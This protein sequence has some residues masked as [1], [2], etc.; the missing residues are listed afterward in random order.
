MEKIMVIMKKDLRETLH[1]KAFYVSIGIALF[2]LVMLSMGL[3]RMSGTLIEEGSSPS[4]ITLTIQSLIGTTTFMLSLMLMMLFCIYINAYT[5]T[6]EKIKRSIESL[7]CTPLS[8]KQIYLG[9]SLAVFLPS[10]ILGLVFTFGS[11]VGINYFFIVPKLGHFVI[12]GAAPL[13]ATL[14]VVPLITFFLASLMTALQLILTNIRWINAAFMGVIFA[15]GFGLSPI[16]K[17]GPS[18]WNLVLLSVGIAAVLA[19]ITFLLSSRVT[20]ERIVLS[21]KG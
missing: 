9:K 5:L 21:S 10:V 11:I 13:A 6:V 15:I 1:T 16:L 12:P 18:S 19:L 4:E 20:K 17:F 14:V 8:L 7:L 3:G 2:V